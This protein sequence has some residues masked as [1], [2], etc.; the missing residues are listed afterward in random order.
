ML[1]PDSGW[2]WFDGTG[3][4]ESSQDS[5]I[6][7]CFVKAFT[8]ANGRLALAHL[9]AITIEQSATPQCSDAMLRHLEG[10]RHI[11]RMIERL[12]GVNGTEEQ[13]K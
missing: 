6:R 5:M 2:A 1:Q 13:S 9:R 12:S 3:V 4:P 8:T 10:Q 11:V 7:D